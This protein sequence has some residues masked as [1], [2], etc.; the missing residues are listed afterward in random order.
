MTL[1]ISCGLSDP[2]WACLARLNYR[3]W[4]GSGFSTCV[5]SCAQAEG[6]MTTWDIL[7]SWDR[8]EAPRGHKNT[9][10]YV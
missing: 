3:R 6:E 1:Q 2:S 8:V 9:F 7:F 4:L 10:K 5:H